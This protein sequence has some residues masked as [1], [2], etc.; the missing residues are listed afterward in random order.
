MS[1][2]DW[3]PMIVSPAQLPTLLQLLVAALKMTFVAPL[4][5]QN[6][7]QESRSGGEGQGD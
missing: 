5:T 1:S 7:R 3:T 4:F 2:L 6:S